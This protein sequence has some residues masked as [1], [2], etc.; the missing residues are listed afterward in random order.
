[1]FLS[2][3]H[4]RDRL[5]VQQQST[6]FYDSPDEC[7]Q[8]Y[9]KEGCVHVDICETSEEPE[10]KTPDESEPGD[11]EPED[12]SPDDVEVEISTTTTTT[13][14]TAAATTTS[15]S[16]TKQTQDEDC[17]GAHE[18]WHPVTSGEPNSW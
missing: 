12:Q 6:I 1:M 10:D 14:T 16:T 13:A 8:K 4:C 18:H 7:C 15:S 5:P 9:W 3:Q 17:E 2:T 11:V